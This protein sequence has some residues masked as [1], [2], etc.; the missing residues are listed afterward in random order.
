MW[1]ILRRLQTML[2]PFTLLIP[3]L[4]SQLVLPRP[5]FKTH[6]FHF[7]YSF[8]SICWCIF[9]LPVLTERG[10]P[11][12]ALSLWSLVAKR[13]NSL[14]TVQKKWNT[15]VHFSKTLLSSPVSRDRERGWKWSIVSRPTMSCSRRRKNSWHIRNCTRGRRI[16]GFTNAT[17]TIWR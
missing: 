4:P 14:P 3:F 15:T 1:R 7:L 8:S 2:T 6:L 16:W 12:P 10:I 9:S 17:P 5:I 13:K 11:S